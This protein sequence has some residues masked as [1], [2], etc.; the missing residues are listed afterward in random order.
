[1]DAQLISP[2]MSGG[3]KKYKTSGL[4]ILPAQIYESQED[5]T[6]FYRSLE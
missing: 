2:G 4:L 6:T 3:F 5:L 1:M